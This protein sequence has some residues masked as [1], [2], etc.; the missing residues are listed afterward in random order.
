MMH[1]PI[2]NEL[3]TSVPPP[4]TPSSVLN[5]TLFCR[6]SYNE[7]YQSHKNSSSIFTGVIY[8]NELLNV[9]ATGCIILLL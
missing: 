4:P 9:P 6:T 3:R 2:N 5:M 1:G 7:P 8:G